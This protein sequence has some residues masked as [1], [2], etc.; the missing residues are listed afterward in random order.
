MGS[1][2]AVFLRMAFSG[3][4]LMERASADLA[5]LRPKDDATRP[6]ASWEGRPRV[7]AKEQ[8]DGNRDDRSGNEQHRGT[9]SH[10]W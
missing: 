5:I 10:S 8:C 2:S 1:A 4:A 6:A 7:L 9:E 3:T